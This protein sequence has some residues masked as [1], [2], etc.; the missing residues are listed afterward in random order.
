MLITTMFSGLVGLTAT[1][2]S[3]SFVARWLTSTFVGG[4]E[5]NALAG[6]TANAPTESTA[7]TTNRLERMFPLLPISTIQT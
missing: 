7:V 1:A 6:P 4:E 3:D 2:S 5:A